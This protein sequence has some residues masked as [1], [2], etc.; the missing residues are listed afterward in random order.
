VTTPEQLQAQAEAIARVRAA[1]IERDRITIELR[2]AIV[3]AL[4][5]GAAVK[6]VAAAAE[7][8]RQRIHQIASETT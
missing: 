6:D 1:R 8:T 7:L 4:N 5:V 3:D 2:R